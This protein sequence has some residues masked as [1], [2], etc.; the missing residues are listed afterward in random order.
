MEN[1]KKYYSI[2]EK[3]RKKAI[4]ARSAVDDISER[5]HEFIKDHNFRELKENAVLWDEYKRGGEEEKKQRAIV[6]LN[7]NIIKSAECDCMRY[8]VNLLQVHLLENIETFDGMP[9]RYKK[10]SEALEAIAGKDFYICP[11]YSGMY[12][13]IGNRKFSYERK[14]TLYFGED[15]YNTKTGKYDAYFTE[16]RLKETNPLSI[17]GADNIEKNVKQAVKDAEKVKKMMEKF[18]KEASEIKSKYSNNSIY[19]IFENEVRF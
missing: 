15:G 13:Y 4:E 6:A 1:I 14:E 10:V 11:E 16:K 18:K 12:F 5:L 3:A 7:E 19:H 2:I 8:V 17:V 9:C